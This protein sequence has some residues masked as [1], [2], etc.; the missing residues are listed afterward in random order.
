MLIIISIGPY[1]GKHIYSAYLNISLSKQ[2][3]THMI[4]RSHHLLAIFTAGNMALQ[5]EYFKWKTVVFLLLCHVGLLFVPFYVPGHPILKAGGHLWSHRQALQ[6]E[7]FK[8]KTVVF[9]LL[10][11]VG[12]LFVPFYVPGHPILKAGGH[13]W[14]HRLITMLESRV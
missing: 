2:G 11:H 7:Y 5:D 14:S 4:G 1:Q 3:P 12:L 6:D 9:L 8:W 10:C 13:L